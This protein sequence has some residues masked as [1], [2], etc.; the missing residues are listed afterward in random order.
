M[1][2]R[3]FLKLTGGACASAIVGC[4]SELSR[5]SSAGLGR[6]VGVSLAGGG[7]VGGESLSIDGEML[8]S[9]NQNRS[10]V[11]CQNGIVCTSQPLASMAGLDT[12]K[13]GGNAIDAAVCANAMLSVVEP[14]SC[15]PGGDLF[16][17][18]WIEKDKKLYGLNASGNTPYDWS[19]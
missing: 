10:T 1:K 16:A 15:G 11:I 8:R 2:R 14:M 19:L 18:V 13:A 4:S 17:I 5:R 9:R 12:L 3:S 7:G 6:G